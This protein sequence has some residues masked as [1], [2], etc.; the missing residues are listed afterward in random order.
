MNVDA[1][2]GTARATKDYLPSST[3]LTFSPQDSAKTFMVEV[4][5]D[6]RLERTETF[7]VDLKDALEA[8]IGDGEGVGRIR[9]DDS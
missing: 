6:R 5:G 3:V 4:R 8:S 9:N 7:F 1:R 2:D